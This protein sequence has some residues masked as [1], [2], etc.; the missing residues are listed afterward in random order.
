MLNFHK[1]SIFTILKYHKISRFSR[2]NFH[3]ISR[4]VKLFIYSLPI[5]IFCVII[6]VRNDIAF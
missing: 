3:K 4:H 6:K 5:G 1:I 2:L